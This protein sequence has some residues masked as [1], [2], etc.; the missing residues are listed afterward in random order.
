MIEYIAYTK[1][2][3]R[4][5]KNEDRIFID[6]KLL[7]EGTLSGKAEDGLVAVVCDGVGGNAGGEIAAEIVANSFKDMD[8]PQMSVVSLN[9]HIQRTNRE[10]MEE[11]ERHP[12]YRNMA[13]TVAG[14][15]LW[16]NQYIFFNM[17]DT[18]I[19]D[20]SGNHIKIKSR[21]HILCNQDKRNYITHYM[22]G[23]GCSGNAHILR[24]SY[25][26]NGKQSFI[27]SDGL[28]KSLSDTDIY[29]SLLNQNSSI[30]KKNR[31]ILK[32]ISQNGSIDDTSYILLSY[33]L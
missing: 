13:S 20:I 1:K 27:C 9:R 31:A 30:D 8:I 12:N 6:N 14:M 33:E 28:Y 25:K 26:E 5:E 15:I 16:K 11:Q 18:R 3:D 21:D 19:Y 23:D 10:I 7:S 4:R 22:G 17:G 2:G 24:G 29:E 32:K